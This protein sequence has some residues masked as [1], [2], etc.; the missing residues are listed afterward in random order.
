MSKINKLT[1]GVFNNI[2]GSNSSVPLTEQFVNTHKESKPSKKVQ[3]L[4]SQYGRIVKDNLKTL[5]DLSDLEL[6]IMQTNVMEQLSTEDI[7]LY[8]LREYLYARTPFPKNDNES[9]DIRVFLGKTSD[10]G[11][12]DIDILIG[13]K[14]FMDTVKQKLIAAMKDEIKLIKQ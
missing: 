1:S 6:E 2:R 5:Q 4:L 12:E 10:S 14:K 9:K 3:R 11:T 7:K 13:N 8:T